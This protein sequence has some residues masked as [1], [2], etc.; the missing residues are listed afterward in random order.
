MLIVWSD[1]MQYTRGSDIAGVSGNDQIVPSSTLEPDPLWHILVF[2]SCVHSQWN[3]FL[4]SAMHKLCKIK[5]ACCPTSHLPC[6]LC[7][8]SVE[9]LVK[10]Q[11]KTKRY[12]LPASHPS[13]SFLSLLTVSALLF[14]KWWWACRNVAVITADVLGDE[15]TAVGL[16]H[17]RYGGEK[18]EW[19]GGVQFFF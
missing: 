13:N 18:G 4:I 15:N 9:S 12:F 2:T 5:R 6:P 14:W 10:H 17:W 16:G 8:F 7:Y 3:I 1:L 19:R 11:M